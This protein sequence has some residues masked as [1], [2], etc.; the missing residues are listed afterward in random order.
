M[1]FNKILPD[2]LRTNIKEFIEDN[3][4]IITGRIQ[5]IPQST[6]YLISDFLKLNTKSNLLNFLN[7]ALNINKTEVLVTIKLKS[8]I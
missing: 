5:K 7:R 1:L 6:N 2:E 4:D 3:W 8:K